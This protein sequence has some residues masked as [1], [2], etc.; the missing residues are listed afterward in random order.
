MR[1]QITTGM[2]VAGML[3]IATAVGALTVTWIGFALAG[4]VLFATGVLEGRKK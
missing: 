2:E 3:L 4:T 1:D